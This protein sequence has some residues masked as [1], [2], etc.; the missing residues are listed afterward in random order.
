MFDLGE[1][2]STETELDRD[3]INLTGFETSR[4]SSSRTTSTT[5][6]TMS[7]W[8]AAAT[9]G[10]KVASPTASALSEMSRRTTAL[11]ASTTHSSLSTS[12]NASIPSGG[13]ASNTTTQKA[14]GSTKTYP[15]SVVG[16]PS[17]WSQPSKMVQL[18]NRSKADDEYGLSNYLVVI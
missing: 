7:S 18:P 14:T 6:A 12:S 1:E 2:D 9:S 5:S 8:F 17:V 16:K 13:P 3:S 4:W 11:E 10:S 15:L